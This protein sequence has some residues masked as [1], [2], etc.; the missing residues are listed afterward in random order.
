MSRFPPLNPLRAF[1]VAGRLKSI[2]NAAK[3]LHVTPGA[4]SRQVHILEQHLGVPLFKRLPRSIMLTEAG[5]RYLEEISR[6]LL[7]I[8]DATE[9][10]T[11]RKGR[12]ILHVRAYITFAMRWLIPRLASFHA[13]HSHVEVRLTASLEAVDFERENVDGAIRLGDPEW[14]GCC[15]DRLVENELVPVCSPAYLAHRGDAPMDLSHDI[16]LH[17]LARPGDWEHWL[18]STGARSASS[19]NQ[20]YQSS[21]L[22]YEAALQ[23]LG[24]AIAQRV[25]VEDDIASGRLVCPFHQSLNMG[26]HTYYLIYPMN[27]LRN[28]AFRL[29]RDWIVEEAS[30]TG[31]ISRAA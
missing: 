5:E 4:V 20:I 25:L 27:R 18:R 30:R 31:N 6:H 28:P 8:Q 2:R 11:G 19:T 16:L 23:G 29:F 14:H 22:A 17:S 10:L 21:V 3:E 12:H 9:R 7:G 24:M 1:E 13:R 26:S 15:R